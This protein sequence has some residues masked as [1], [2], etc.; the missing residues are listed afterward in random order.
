MG[1]NETGSRGFP[2]GGLWAKLA[3][4]AVALVCVL[5]PADA[6]ASTLLPPKGKV[7]VG[8]AGA[9]P[10]AWWTKATGKHS[11]VQ[12]EFVTWGSGTS[13]AFAM[14]AAA[15]ARPMLSISTG[16]LHHERISPRAMARGHGDDFLLRLNTQIHEYGKPTYVRL[17][18]EMNGNWNPYCA[19]SANGRSRGP[20]H[21]TAMFRQAWRRAVIVVRGGRVASINR[22]LRRL[23]LPALHGRHRTDSLPKVPVSFLWV[24]QTAGNPD[25]RANGPRAYW[26]GAHYVD[27]VGTDFYS[28][29]PNYRGLERFYREFRHKPVVF[30]EWAMWGADNPG[31]V[32]TLF[33]W[34]RSHP[35]VRMMI[36][37][38]G[39]RPSGPFIL[40]RYPA[41]SRALRGLLRNSRYAS[42]AQ[43]FSDE[44]G[45]TVAPITPPQQGVDT[46]VGK[47]SGRVLVADANGTFTPLKPGD[48]V[49]LGVQVDTRQGS[50]QL[51]GAVGSGRGA[52]IHAT[53]SR[54][55]FTGRQARSSRTIDIV[56]ARPSL[57]SGLSAAHAAA[58]P[59]RTPT[60]CASATAIPGAG[61]SGP[62][63]A[64][65]RVPRLGRTGSRTS[66]AT[67][68]RRRCCAE[69][70]ASA[71]SGQ[72]RPS[73]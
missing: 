60:A 17:M 10:S 37:N 50:V 67:A 65:P 1:V 62:S 27:W 12:Q 4:M 28:K 58:S 45:D 11:P 63:A 61:D 18:A 53:L 52:T 25:T 3:A 33:S 34:S 5:G 16:A 21:S 66:A 35:R 57:C 40:R 22:R 32:H 48:P 14:A 9:N 72:A 19:Y 55:I 30:G 39:N 70:S 24:P 20:S 8:L 54:G 44:G 26:P 69:A 41:A 51:F 68:R 13:W 64:I 38:Q 49:P 36:Y 31:F 73:S 42:Y 15:R 46:T 2:P 29:F 43:E 6:R 23:G 71:T 56:M 7:F 47:V 59:D